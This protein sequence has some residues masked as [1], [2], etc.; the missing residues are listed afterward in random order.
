M[1]RKYKFR[2]GDEWSAE[3]GLSY[4]MTVAASRVVAGR[5]PFSITQDGEVVAQN[6][7]R[8][9]VLVRF[10]DL[11]SHR[12]VGSTFRIRKG[13][14]DVVFTARAVE[15]ERLPADSTSGNAKA[16]EFYNWVMTKYKD[17]KPRYAGAYVCKLVSGSTSMSQHSYGNA[18]DF[19]FDSI[20]HQNEVFD[21][22]RHGRA[23]VAVA[24]AISE[25]KIWSPSG[26]TKAY[27]G[28]YHGHLHVDFL[29]QQSGRCGVKP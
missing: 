23:P 8:K 27:G 15:S 2:K 18:I 7:S 16:D 11:I 14:G 13:D 12:D 24:H 1:A 17:W 10:R 4:L 3:H 6:K 26:G 5:G 22:V 21:D 29:P 9:D 19:F 20:K 25:R 28:D